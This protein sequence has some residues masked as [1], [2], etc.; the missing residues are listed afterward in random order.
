M[1][2]MRP[3]SG[4]LDSRRRA[5]DPATAAT[6]IGMLTRKIQ[7]HESHDVSIPPTSGPIA[8][9][10]PT[11]APQIPNAVPR[12]RPWNSCESSAS[13]VENMIAPPI[14][15]SARAR[16]RNSGSLAAP[17]RAD[18]AVKIT[19]PVTKTR[20]RPKRSATDPAVSVQVASASAYAST[21]HCRSENDA[22]S[23]LSIAGSATF[24]IVMSSRSMKI[25]THTA[26][27]VHHFRSIDGT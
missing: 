1:G 10:A 2:S 20:L 25:A 12:S 8:T 21:T 17:Q 9:A 16:I 3:C 23:D 22:F 6:P 19:I 27:S 15:C 24:T 11:V 5:T 13:D 14:P 4:S 7:R 18:A 26:S